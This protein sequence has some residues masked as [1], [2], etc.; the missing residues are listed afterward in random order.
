[1]AAPPADPLCLDQPPA[2]LLLYLL[3][4]NEGLSFNLRLEL[5]VHG[6]RIVVEPSV[7]SI[8]DAQP[9]PQVPSALTSTFLLL[10]CWHL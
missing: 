9:L 7:G 2:E 8:W 10:C 4:K 3:G 6:I 1:M 5:N